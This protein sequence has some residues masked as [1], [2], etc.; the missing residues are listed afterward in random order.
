VSKES[1]KEVWIGLLGVR[2][3]PD[4]NVLKDVAGAYVNVLTWASD[5]EEFE[6]KA[7]ELMDHLRLMLVRIEN[8]EPL[9]N[10]SAPADSDDDLAAI[11]IQVKR[12]PNAIMYGK[13]H[14]WT[15]K[16]I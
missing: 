7:Q 16:N 13:F 15:E 8:P 1:Q 14:S 5:R 4:S 12:N 3:L 6:R 10:R 9:N 2:S 11:A